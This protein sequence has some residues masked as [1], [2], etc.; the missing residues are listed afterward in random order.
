MNTLLDTNI[1]TRAAQLGH[2][3]N[4]TAADAVDAL[5][6]R[7]DN[8][9]IVPQSLYEF[10]VV[11]TRPLAQN[12]LGF[13]PAQ[14]R[15]EIDQFKKSFTLLP[16]TPAIFPAWEHLVTSYAVSGKSAHDARLVAAMQVHGLDQLLTFNVADFRR[17]AIITVLD[18]AV[19]VSSSPQL[20]PV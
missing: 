13:S 16:D 11:G 6:R 5:R 14:V 3:M 10:W 7:G 4:A 2:P 8:L 17:Y 9:F 12:G 15:T 1:L 18:P 20:R 19:V